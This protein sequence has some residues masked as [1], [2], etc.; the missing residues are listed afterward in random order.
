M[1]TMKKISVPFSG[2]LSWAVAAF[3]AWIPFGLGISAPLA[4]QGTEGLSPK[5]KN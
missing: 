1:Q 3:P 4:A 2:S 5:P